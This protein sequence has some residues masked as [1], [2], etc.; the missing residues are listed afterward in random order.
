M[1]HIYNV[2][3]GWDKEFI[4]VLKSICLDKVLHNGEEILKSG[5]I[6]TE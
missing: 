3:I 5:N 2:L 4:D 1:T 6:L